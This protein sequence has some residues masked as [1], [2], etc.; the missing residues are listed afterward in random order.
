LTK[1]I[2]WVK[3]ESREGEN[4]YRIKHALSIMSDKLTGILGFIAFASIILSGLADIILPVTWTKWYF[5]SGALL[6]SQSVSIKERHTTIPPA[7]L[8]NKRL[9]SF[10]MSG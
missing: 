1:L 5:A 7:A 6:F 10:L 3:N 4:R 2:D 8:F 9:D